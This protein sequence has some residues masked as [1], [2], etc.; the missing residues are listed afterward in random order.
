MQHAEGWVEY[1][2]KILVC[3]QEICDLL[4]N[5]KEMVKEDE[6]MDAVNHPQ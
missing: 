3:F 6:R 4:K 5:N 2:E 1:V